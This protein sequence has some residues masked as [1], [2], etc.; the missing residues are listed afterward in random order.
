MPDRKQKSHRRR[1]RVLFLTHENTVIHSPKS[2][3][4]RC[5]MTTILTKRE[6]RTETKRMR[7]FRC[8]LVMRKSMM[9]RWMM[10]SAQFFLTI[11]CLNRL[12]YQFLLRN[13]S[14]VFG[15]AHS[16][17][18]L[19]VFFRHRLRTHPQVWSFLSLHFDSVPDS[20]L[21]LCFPPHSSSILRAGFLPRPPHGMMGGFLPPPPPPFHLQ[22]GQFGGSYGPAFG[23]PAVRPARPPAGKDPMLAV[24]DE[25]EPPRPPPPAMYTQPPILQGQPRPPP[26][27]PAEPEARG[28]NSTIS[29]APVIRDKAAELKKLVPTSLLV[30][31][32]QPA[33]KP[34]VPRLHS[35]FASTTPATPSNAVS[36]SASSGPFS[37]APSSTSTPAAVAVQPSAVSQ[38]APASAASSKDLAYQQFMAELGGLL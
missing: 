20:F 36:S 34:V 21:V 12:L 22:G 13:I 33:K 11:L 6:M 1:K 26:R 16:L 28:V 29:A 35:T 2:R 5:L 38:A 10:K 24:F 23:G 14:Q 3:T 17:R 4:S 15:L 27:P 31:R 25:E 9:R 32:P 7:I 37:A 19:R 30:R 18:P 8:R